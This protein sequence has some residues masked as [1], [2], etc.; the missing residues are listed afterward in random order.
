MASLLLLCLIS[1]RVEELTDVCPSACVVTSPSCGVGECL[2][3]VVVRK[4]LGSTCGWQLAHLSSCWVLKGTWWSMTWKARSWERQQFA[5]CSCSGDSGCSAPQISAQHSACCSSLRSLELYCE[6][7]WLS[8]WCTFPHG[9]VKC[10]SSLS[11]LFCSSL[12]PPTSPSLFLSFINLAK[13]QSCTPKS[14]S[15]FWQFIAMG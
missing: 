3:A 11:L 9:R 12:P 7:L 14:V 8:S 15:F 10:C 4:G 1:V 2:H 13:C 5:F 6:A